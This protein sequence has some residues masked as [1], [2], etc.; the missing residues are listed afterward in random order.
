MWRASSYIII[1]SLPAAPRD[2]KLGTGKLFHY[3]FPRFLQPEVLLSR[4]YIRADL[5]GDHVVT[6]CARLPR[7]FPDVHRSCA[8]P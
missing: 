4:N 8:V 2:T 5:H 1:I 3:T 7:G 6:L